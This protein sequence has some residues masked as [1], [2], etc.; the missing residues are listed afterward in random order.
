VST[1]TK[2]GKTGALKRINTPNK[3]DVNPAKNASMTAK[4]KP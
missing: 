2:K 3:I 1:K 4:A